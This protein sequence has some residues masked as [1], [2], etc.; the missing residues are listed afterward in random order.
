[1]LIIQGLTQVEEMLIS[2]V[3]PIMTVCQLPYGQC[4]CRG[5]IINLPQDV[6]TFA[7]RLPHHPASLDII[8]VIRR[9]CSTDSH[10]D[11]KVRRS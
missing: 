3:M 5:H 8:V 7:T 9:Q 10:Q 11:L 2:A 1:M 6:Y 4:G